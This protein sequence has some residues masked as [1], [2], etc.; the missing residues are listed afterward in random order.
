MIEI[1]ALV[2]LCKKNGN[3]AIRKGLKSRTWKLYTIL[4][5]ICAEFTG[6]IL[7]TILFGQNNLYGILA[8]GLV[9]AFG[10]YLIIR[11]ILEKKPDSLDNDIDRIGADELRPPAKSD[12]PE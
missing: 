1:I 2:F 6:I 12:R 8:L 7:G 4:A 10:G 5:W 9:S 11:S 3:L